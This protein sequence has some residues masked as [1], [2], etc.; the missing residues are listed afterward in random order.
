MAFHENDLL[1]MQHELDEHSLIRAEIR[2]LANRGMV[3]LSKSD[4]DQLD[5]L[6]DILQQISEKTE[7][8]S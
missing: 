3:I 4:L 5:E 7:Q 8:L 6:Y 1:D 2:R